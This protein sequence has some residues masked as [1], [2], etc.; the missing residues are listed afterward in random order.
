MFETKFLYYTVCHTSWSTQFVW[1]SLC[2][3]FCVTH[4]LCHIVCVTQYVLHCLR[5]KFC[6]AHFVFQSLCHTFSV[7]HLVWHTL[8]ST[9]AIQP[10]DAGDFSTTCCPRHGRTGRPVARR[11]HQADPNIT[12]AQVVFAQIPTS[13]RSYSP[14]C[15]LP[16]GRLHPNVVFT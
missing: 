1:H 5:H 6:V 11:R 13:L 14:R 7:T 15:R 3:T 9:L 12:D 4:L 10:L 16:I 2:H 8:P